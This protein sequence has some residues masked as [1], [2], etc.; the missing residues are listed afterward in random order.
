MQASVQAFP[1]VDPVAHGCPFLR[2]GLWGA[3]R[4]GLVTMTLLVW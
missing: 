4:I 1:D 3:I 2:H